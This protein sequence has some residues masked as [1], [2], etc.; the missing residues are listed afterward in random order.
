VEW[1]PDKRENAGRGPSLIAQ[2]RIDELWE[3]VEAGTVRAPTGICGC[4]GWLAGSS[5]CAG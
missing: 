1:D 4:C 5:R 2:A 3:G